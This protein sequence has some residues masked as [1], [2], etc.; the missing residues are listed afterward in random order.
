MGRAGMRVMLGRVAVARAEK[1]FHSD[2][3]GKQV[4]GDV[5]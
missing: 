1:G 2:D 3:G 5:P 4:W